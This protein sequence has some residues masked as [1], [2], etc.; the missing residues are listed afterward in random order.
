M[1]TRFHIY[2]T[3]FY[4]IRT[5]YNKE[6]KKIFKTLNQKTDKKP[7]NYENNHKNN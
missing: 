7:I 5:Y 1:S 4:I 6:G 3:P 2:V